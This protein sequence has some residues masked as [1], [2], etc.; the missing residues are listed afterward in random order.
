MSVRVPALLVRGV[1]GGRAH[2]CH[3][4]NVTL[5]ASAQKAPGSSSK[6]RNASRPSLVLYAPVS[7][8]TRDAHNARALEGAS[9]VSSSM[10]SPPPPGTQHQQQTLYVFA[11]QVCL[12]Y[13]FELVRLLC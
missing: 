11:V 7:L 10:P 8:R 3:A 5:R 6:H 13:D 4:F 12:L 2:S 1:G 9:Q